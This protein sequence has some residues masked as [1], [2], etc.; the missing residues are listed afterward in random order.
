[1]KGLLFGGCSFTWGQG[2]YYYSDKRNLPK[3]NL[4]YGFT[5]KGITKSML[6]FKNQLRYPNIVANHFKTFYLFKKD[7]GRLLGNGGSETETF[8]FFDYIF[9]VEK[10]YS[11]SDFEY[12][13]IQLSNVFRNDFIFEHGGFT[14]R[15]KLISSGTL[16]N[17]LIFGK[18]FDDYLVQNNYQFKDLE[19]IFLNNCFNNLKSRVRHYE[20]WGLKVK[21]IC[22]NYDYIP[23]ITYDEY[24]RGKLIDLEYNDKKY[25]CI[26]AL[27]SNNKN[28]TIEDDFKNTKNIKI[29]DK[30]PSKLC[31]EIIAESIIKNIEND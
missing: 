10:E 3:N 18:E 29:E 25:N 14:H 16:N 2:L 8:D 21:L 11:H 31:H 27:I 9:N 12:V 5:T 23:F 19:E 13:I 26:D 24:L 17:E 20:D 7:I 6:E 28:M 4:S 30:H 22:M 15:R 1:M